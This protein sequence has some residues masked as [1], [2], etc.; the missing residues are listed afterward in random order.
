MGYIKVPYWQWN[1][2]PDMID[3][4]V[5]GDWD[6]GGDVREKFM[7]HCFPTLE[8]IQHRIE[9]VRH[10]HTQGTIKALFILTDTNQEFIDTLKQRL[11]ASMG[12]QVFTSRDLTLSNREK[13]TQPGIDMAIAARA[14]LFLGNGVGPLSSFLLTLS[15]MKARSFRLL[16]V[17]SAS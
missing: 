13:G 3:K 6:G 4:Y 14:E 12:V 2:L 1:A 11:S 17:T 5:P 8:Q 7:E 10:E 16:L 15:L 9:Q